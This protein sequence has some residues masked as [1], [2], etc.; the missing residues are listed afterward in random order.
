MDEK[1]FT[2]ACELVIGRDKPE[3]GIG[4]YGEKTLHMVLK[5]YLEPDNSFHEIPVGSFI[6]DIFNNGEI[7]EIQTRDFNK[8]RKK[9]DF[10]LND[11]AVTVVYPVPGLKWL[12]WIDPE[13]G[14][15]TKKRRSAKRGTGREIFA[16]LYKI[17]HLLTRQNLCFKILLL[18]LEEYRYLN[19]WSRDK[20]RGSSRYDRIPVGIIDSISIS[21]LKDYS[22][23]IPDSL[24]TE[25]TS[26]DFKAASGLNLSN[27]QTALN[28]LHSVGAV[29]K[30]GKRSRS[31]LY[32]RAE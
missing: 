30:K 25:F 4:T 9:L 3:N 27:S 16:E 29:V 6:A 24:D 28:V 20:K 11:Y 32:E 7:T 1:R 15:T 19:G 12:V 5:N 8:L 10:F 31:I 13:T 18:E 14:E 21:C 22:L 17:K 23:L 26:A 2:K